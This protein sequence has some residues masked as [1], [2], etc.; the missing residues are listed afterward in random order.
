MGL[1]TFQDQNTGHIWLDLDNFFN[2]TFNDMKAT[3]VAAG[4]TVANKSDVSQLLSSLPDPNVN[5]TSYTAIM[6]E[7]PNRALIWGAYDQTPGD[8]SHDWAYSWSDSDSWSYQPNAYANNVVPNGGSRD[9][10]MNLWA[11]RGG[12]VVPLPASF[13]LLGPGLAAVAVLR[14]KMK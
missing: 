8:N 3:A 10:D 4:F 12:A 13:L 7:A 9:A 1:K 14:R 2:K 5:W 6:G 11:Y